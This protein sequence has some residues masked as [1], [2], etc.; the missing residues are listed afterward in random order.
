MSHRIACYTLFNIN[1]TGVLNRAR[2]SES[3]DYNEWLFKRNTQC[4]FDTILQSISLRSQPEVI[5]FPTV[6]NA[7]VKKFG[8]KYANIKNLKVWT[9]EFEI[10]HD[11][12]FNDEDGDL[13][14]LYK[15]VQGVPMI[16]FKE[17]CKAL[18]NYL[19]NTKDY[20]NI[21]FIKY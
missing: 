15:D 17:D 12:V 13:G 16:K 7:D 19:D 21:Y 5:K 6:D 3:E 11:S 20:K 2:P 1:Q 4:N 8:L 14:A 18:P 10:Y 9:F